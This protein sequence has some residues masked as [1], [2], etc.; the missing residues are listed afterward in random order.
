MSR[1]YVKLVLAMV[2]WGATWSVGRAVVQEVPPFAAA[3]FRFVIAVACMGLWLWHAEGRLPRMRGREVLLLLAL[4]F[5]GIFL[6]NAFF[7]H[8]LQHIDASRAA[9]VVALNPVAIALVS[10]ALGQDRLSPVKGL[11]L[12]LALA[13]SVWVISRGD[14]A[15]LWY[16]GLGV[17]E[18]LILGCVAAWTFY[19]LAGRQATTTMSPLAVNVWACGLGCL[20]LGGAAAVEGQ[21]AWAW[22][23]YS[24]K[25]WA[26]LF[27]LGVFGTAVSYIWYTEGVRSLGAARAAVFINLVPL[28]GVLIATLALHERLPAAVWAGGGLSLVGVAVTTLAGVSQSQRAS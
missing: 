7:L 12:A 23:L 14:P 19:T 9:L 1:V 22:P 6:Y 27:F 3:F 26:C 15:S 5:T 2:F 16:E 18:A 25:A 24:L 8:G 28:S 21:G 11:G 10:A 4:G 13:G 20:L 17:G